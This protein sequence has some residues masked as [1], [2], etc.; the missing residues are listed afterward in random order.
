M[1]ELPDFDPKKHKPFGGRY[2]LGWLGILVNL[3]MGAFLAFL[4]G[5]T[6][7]SI[8]KGNL[9]FI[10][11]FT[12]FLIPTTLFWFWRTSR[13]FKKCGRPAFIILITNLSISLADVFSTVF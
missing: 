8:G 5:Y 6:L 3:I 13:L 9:A 10:L 4:V 1:T 11:I 2:W 7:F 12:L